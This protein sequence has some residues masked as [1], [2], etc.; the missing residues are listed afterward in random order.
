MVLTFKNRAP[1]HPSLIGEEKPATQEDLA[2]IKTPQTWAWSV[3]KRIVQ[4]L[5]RGTF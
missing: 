1:L 4:I 5:L 2:S 3:T